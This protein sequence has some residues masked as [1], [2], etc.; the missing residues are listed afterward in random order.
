MNTTKYIGPLSLL[1]YRI[2]NGALH[3]SLQIKRGNIVY[4]IDWDTTSQNKAEDEALLKI[5]EFK[6]F[7]LTNNDLGI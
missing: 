5:K 6:D 2:V 3:A 1:T 4:R 7:G